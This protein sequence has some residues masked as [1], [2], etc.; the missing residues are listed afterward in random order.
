[1]THLE[2]AVELRPNMAAA[3]FYLGLAQAE[4]GRLD[5]AGSSFRRT[6]A[7]DPTHTRAY[8]ALGRALARLD[9]RPEALR[10]LRHGA[11]HAAESVA[12]VEVLAEPEAEP[13]ADR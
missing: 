3:W 4:L 5:A 2:R 9:R 6:L 12:I 11:E 13:A 7:L 10:V 1:M 8:L